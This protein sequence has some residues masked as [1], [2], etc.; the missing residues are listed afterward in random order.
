MKMFNC[1]FHVI[2]LK[3]ETNSYNSLQISSEKKRKKHI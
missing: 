3:K 1:T 2:F